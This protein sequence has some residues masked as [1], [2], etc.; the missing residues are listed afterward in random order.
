[1]LVA[2]N[3][4]FQGVLVGTV[5][6]Q[7]IS[8]QVRGVD[9]LTIALTIALGGFAVADALY[10]NVKERAAEFVT[11]RTVGWRDRDTI[12]LVAAEA[13]AMGAIGSVGGAI[14]G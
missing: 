11:L 12:R 5:M 13:I 8:L 3:H 9:L 7:F 1:M 2:I 6:G 10:L 14:V 4:A